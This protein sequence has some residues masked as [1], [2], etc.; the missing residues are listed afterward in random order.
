M[1][2]DNDISP[3][4]DRS[5]HAGLGLYIVRSI[6][7]LHHGE[8]GAVNVDN[9]VEFWMRLPGNLSGNEINEDVNRSK[10]VIGRD[11]DTQTK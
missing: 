10:K 8:C 4:E 9:G 5:M 2:G 7:G 1:K 11:L 6:V 3:Q